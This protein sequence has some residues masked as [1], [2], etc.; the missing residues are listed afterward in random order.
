MSLNTAARRRKFRIPKAAWITLVIVAMAI[1]AVVACQMRPK[2]EK[3]PYRFA[4]VERGDI[5]R[6]V[7]A[8]G[9]LQA[10]ITVD[11]GSQIS[12]Q[13]T[14][15]LVDFND[16]VRAGQTLAILDPQTYQS[17]V[18]Q[19]QADIAAGQAGVRQAQATL[20]NAQAD[21]NRKKT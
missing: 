11:V 5:T 8:S 6:S 10:L 20:A 3:D 1:A 17:R 14:K 21:Y 13:V 9:S 7:S 19:S 2:P 4:S 15:V 18:A 12:G 16:Q